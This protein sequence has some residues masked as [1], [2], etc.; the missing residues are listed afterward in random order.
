MTYPVISDL[1][2]NTV[3]PNIATALSKSVYFHHGHILEISNTI[4]QMSTDPDTDKRFPFIALKRDIE[5]Q[6][7]TY[8]GIE[9]NATFYLIELSSPD[10]TAEERLVNIFK[11]LLTPLYEEF[12]NQIAR[13]GLFLEQS[14]EEIEAVS[15]YTEHYFWG[16]PQVMGPD[17]NIFG[18]WVE[19]I[20]VRIKLT[21]LKNC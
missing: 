7:R 17:A 1:F 5:N 16:T 4:I 11:P 20:E 18:N 12:N 21:A 13:S 19:C 10:Y 8:D 6:K 3:V 9:F 2:K 15:D 14:V